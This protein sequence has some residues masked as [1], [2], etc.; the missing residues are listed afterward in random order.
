MLVILFFILL[1][2][3]QDIISK[4]IFIYNLYR[5]TTEIDVPALYHQLVDTYHSSESE[6]DVEDT[7]NRPSTST[8]RATSSRN[9]RSPKYQMIGK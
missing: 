8:Q 6:V 2:F 4:N 3:Y 9:L 1:Y 7:K 5:E